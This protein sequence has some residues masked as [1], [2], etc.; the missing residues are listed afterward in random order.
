M[1]C[2]EF[3]RVWNAWLDARDD[4]AAD[5]EL[6]REMPAAREHARRCAACARAEFGYEALRRALAAWGREV[7]TSASAHPDLAECLLAALSSPSGSPSSHPPSGRRTGF[8]LP[9][10]FAVAAAAAVLALAIAPDRTRIR[11]GRSTVPAP[12]R[13]LDARVLEESLTEATAATLDLARRTSEPAA[14]LG[15]AVL[16]AAARAEGVEG[17]GAPVTLTSVLRGPIDL[18]PSSTLFQEFGERVSA[19]VRPLS[20]TARR[21][22]EFL[23]APTSGPNGRR[24]IPPTSKGA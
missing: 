21:A 22:F 19:G 12:S 11:P 13:R 5:R 4:R 10:W 3:D 23:L 6:A 16:E 7:R 14:R 20:S 2:R 8:G 18:A 9:L 17:Q 15:R 24:I 1:D